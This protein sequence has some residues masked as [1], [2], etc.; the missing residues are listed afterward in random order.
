MPENVENM[1]HGSIHV[2]IR[3]ITARAMRNPLYQQA[4]RCYTKEKEIQNRFSILLPIKERL[5]FTSEYIAEVHVVTGRTACN[6]VQ[7]RSAQCYEIA[8]PFYGLAT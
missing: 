7:E 3:L 2:L 5:L 1:A 8:I 4:C 6:V